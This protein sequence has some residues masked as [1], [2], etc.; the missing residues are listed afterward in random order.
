MSLIRVLG[1]EQDGAVLTPSRAGA[2]SMTFT[3]DRLPSEQVG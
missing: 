1:F 2:L 3:A